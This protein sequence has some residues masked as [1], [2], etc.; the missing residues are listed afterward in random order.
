MATVRRGGTGVRRA[1][2]AK[3]RAGRAR[4]ARAQTRSVL[5]VA[6][7]YLPFT[8][9]QL[10]RVFLVIIL[11]AALALAWFVA[12]LAGLPALA[13]E[14]FAAATGSAGFAVKRVTVTGV[15]RMNEQSVYQHAL[16]RRD[17]PI[18][19]LDVEALRQELLTLPWVADARVSRRLP[20]L[21]A[22][23]I[24]EREPHAVLAKPD[25]L[26]LIDR[27]GRELQPISQAAA[28]GMLRVHG[29]GAARQV[30]ELDRLLDTAPALKPKVRQAEWIGNRRWNLTF[31][32]GQ[33]LAL[34]QDEDTAA[35]AL[36]KFARLDGTNRLLGGKVAS[37]DMRSPNRIYMRIPGRADGET[38]ALANGGGQE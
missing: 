10:Q 19:S 17:Q 16:A 28:A 37:F 35:G 25:R 7:A 13:G 32:T 6:L 8:E 5:D 33:V 27:T 15:E 2:A 24:V 12:S 9:R 1:A 3:G 22:I 30:G 18:A 14:R 20:D 31:G 26:M 38:L 4:A 23:D 21:I 29:P 11:A 36:V 34:P